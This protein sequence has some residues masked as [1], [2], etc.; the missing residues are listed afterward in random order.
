MLLAYL[1]IANLG[2][3]PSRCLLT[4]GGKE[5]STAER[6]ASVTTWVDGIRNASA[7]LRDARFSELAEG[8]RH[9]L[10]S[11]DVAGLYG[12]VIALITELLTQRARARFDGAGDDSDDD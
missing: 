4:G 6:T 2:D 12:P 11:V 10:R 1:E 9:L 7:G 5:K 3:L 8:F